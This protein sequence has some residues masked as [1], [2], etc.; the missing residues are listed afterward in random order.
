MPLRCRQRRGRGVEIDAL[1][2]GL[3][4][5]PAASGAGEWLWVVANRSRGWGGLGQE[6]RL[7]AAVAVVGAVGS[8]AGR[9]LEEAQRRELWQV[10]RRAPHCTTVRSP[11]SLGAARGQ[12]TYRSG[13]RRGQRPAPNVGATPYDRQVS[14]LPRCGPRAGDLSVRQSAEPGDPC[15]TLV[16]T[17]KIAN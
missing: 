10:S 5:G 16:A 2:E 9:D 12:E 15:R 13:H 6:E 1:G 11:G 7:V 17:Q 3:V 14:R 4:A 8:A